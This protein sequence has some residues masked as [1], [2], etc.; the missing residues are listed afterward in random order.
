LEFFWEKMNAHSVVFAVLAVCIV[1]AAA[2]AEEKLTNEEVTKLRISTLSKP[3]QCVK[4]AKNG[5]KLTMHYRGTLLDGTVFD[6]SY[7]RGEPFSFVLGAGMVI[8][9]WEEGI[10]GMC[11]GERRRLLIPASM[12]YGDR[13]IGQIPANSALLFEIE[14]L[15]AEPAEPAEPKKKRPSPPPKYPKRHPP[16]FEH[17]DL[18]HPDLDHPEFDHPEFD[19]PELRHP[20]LRHPELHH[21]DHD[22]DITEDIRRRLRHHDR[23]EPPRRDRLERPDR[24][25]RDR[26]RPHRRHRRER[27]EL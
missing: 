4:V 27:E 21:P 8:R 7:K 13:A 2:E 12:G 16:R 26:D 15:D 17:P 23:P 19:H 11:V 22:D 5:D 9:G 1:F 14:L 10:P 18:D 3:E 6:E 24:H 20:E 25:R